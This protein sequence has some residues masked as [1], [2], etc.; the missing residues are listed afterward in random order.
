MFDNLRNTIDFNIRN[1][2]KFSRK[3]YIEKNQKIIT[4]TKAE[5]KY[6]FDVLNNSFSKNNK[7]YIK[8]LDIGSKNWFYAKGEY[9]Y[10][11][12]FCSNF[13][14]IGIELD[15]YRLYSNFYSRYEVAQYHI[16]DLKNTE[17]KAEN[18]LNINEKFDYITWFLPFIFKN[19][20][21]YWG[22]PQK[23]YQ[24]EILL[25]HAYN[26][27]NKDG[28][29]LIVN[30]GIKEKNQQEKMLQK[31]N[32]SYKYLGEIKNNFFQYEN[33]RFGFIIK[34]TN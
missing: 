13:S 25:N 29:L 34:K 31:L 26:I 23:Y 22:L 12:S 33:Q 20:L 24:P 16:K 6:I 5:N 19:S 21:I 7:K 27:L 32:I 4:R 28:Q 9:N 30:Q 2:T 14:L 1:L 15:A 17:Y 10:F 11:N 8:I 3:N 18:L